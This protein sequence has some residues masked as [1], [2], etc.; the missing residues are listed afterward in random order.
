MTFGRLQGTYEQTAG[1]KCSHI[2]HTRLRIQWG[3]A[4]ELARQLCE[5]PTTTCR[6]A[7]LPDQ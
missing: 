7:A 6:K 5:G 4:E 2:C 1:S 3:A